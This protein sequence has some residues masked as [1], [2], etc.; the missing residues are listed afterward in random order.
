M[1]EFIVSLRTQEGQYRSYTRRSATPHITAIEVHDPMAGHRKLF[2]MLSD[3][4]MHNVTA[5]LATLK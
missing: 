5:Y 1:D 2:T 3:D 4:D